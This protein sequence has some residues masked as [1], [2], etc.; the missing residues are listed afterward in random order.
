MCE[1]WDAYSDYCIKTTK[2]TTNLRPLIDGYRQQVEIL[3][4]EFADMKKQRLQSDKN[5]FKSSLETKVTLATCEK[6]ITDT[7]HRC[8]LMYL[9]RSLESPWQRFWS[10]R[11]QKSPDSLIKL[12]PTLRS[13]VM[14]LS[15][16]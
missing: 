11:V 1:Y 2:W 4:Q 6:S 13:M 3:K 14:H 5:A 10:A 15:V 7:K 12:A 8:L 9:F 16:S